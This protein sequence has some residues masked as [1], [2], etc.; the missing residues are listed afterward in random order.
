[1]SPLE[2]ED[3]HD[4]E[5]D[6]DRGYDETGLALPAGHGLLRLSQVCERQ[7][8]VGLAIVLVL[9]EREGDVDGGLVLLEELVTLGGAPGDGAEDPAVLLERHLEV[10]LL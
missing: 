1:A 2:R 6:A 8:H 9:F 5:H 4:E 7:L 3:D 10:A